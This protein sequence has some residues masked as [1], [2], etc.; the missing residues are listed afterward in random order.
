[1]DFL[2]KVVQETALHQYGEKNQ[3]L[4]CFKEINLWFVYL[5]Q[6]LVTLVKNKVFFFALENC[7]F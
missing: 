1:M 6:L 3:Y 4:H 5:Q 2:H 7:Y